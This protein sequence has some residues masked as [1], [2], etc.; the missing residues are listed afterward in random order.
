[1]EILG[2]CYHIVCR[3]VT[4]HDLS[5]A[6]QGAFLQRLCAMVLFV[7]VADGFHG[8]LWRSRVDEDCRI[9]SQEIDPFKVR[10]DRVAFL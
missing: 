4:A 7:G 2:R 3:V 8:S 1:V 9:T 5:L 10:R 6:L